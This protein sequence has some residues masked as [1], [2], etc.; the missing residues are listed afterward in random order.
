[1]RTQRG[2]E[3][4]VEHRLDK[5]SKLFTSPASVTPSSAA[6]TI[7]LAT[8]DFEVDLVRQL[9]SARQ[10]SRTDANAALVGMA[11]GVATI[12]A[13]DADAERSREFGAKLAAN[14][15]AA[16]AAAIFTWALSGGKRSLDRT[17]RSDRGISSLVE[18]TALTENADA[19]NAQ[20]TAIRQRNG[21]RLNWVWDAHLEGCPVCTARHG[22]PIAV[23]GVPPAH[24]H[25][26][27]F[28]APFS[29]GSERSTKGPNGAAGPRSF[30]AKRAPHPYDPAGTPLRDAFNVSSGK[31]KA[32]TEE[33]LAAIHRV[34]GD[35][36]HLR[37]PVLWT[38]KRLDHGEFNYL[39]GGLATD[40]RVSRAALHPRL[41][42]VHE[43]GH[44]IDNQAVG[45]LGVNSSVND[46]SP[47][48]SVMDA[49]RSTR[50]HAQLES[51]VGRKQVLIQRHNEP[52]PRRTALKEG[53]AEYL[54]QPQE[55]FARA[56]A[57]YVAVRSGDAAL[58]EELNLSHRHEDALIYGDSWTDEDFHPVA[59]AL[60]ELF[61]SLGWMRAK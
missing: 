37:I 32:A 48:R 29:R 25:C 59:K 44:F 19:F 1:M 8:R 33:G 52:R 61:T 7:N 50:S 51:L 24:P 27:C 21:D 39:R 56:Y 22:R 18:R 15:K 17:L 5:I 2:I 23:T 55:L 40:L 20:L 11:V 26:Q 31:L 4:T 60:D 53:H 35:G 13:L 34:H 30:V 38:N 16:A 45:L 10:A 57:R 58:L 54:L 36:D 3:R 49:I 47:L 6:R 43:V 12:V 9:L 46:G 14:I 28:Q 41:T 42:I